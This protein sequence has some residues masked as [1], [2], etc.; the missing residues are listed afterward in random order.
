MSIAL[1]HVV[2]WP[3]SSVSIGNVRVVLIQVAPPGGHVGMAEETLQSEDVNVLAQGQ[4][5]NRGNQHQSQ[6]NVGDISWCLSAA[7]RRRLGRQVPTVPS[8]PLGSG[9]H[10]TPPNGGVFVTP[11]R[12]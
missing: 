3:A 11:R 12:W 4:R 8:T 9:Q 6:P 10:K 2:H 5:G 7:G 1:Q